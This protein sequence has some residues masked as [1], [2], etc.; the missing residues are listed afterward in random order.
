M[1]AESTPVP[2]SFTKNEETPFDEGEGQ[3]EENHYDDDNDYVN[4]D[5]LA[6]IEKEEEKAREPLSSS[7]S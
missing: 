7:S 6:Y 1:M 2:T 4:E 3:N 5:D